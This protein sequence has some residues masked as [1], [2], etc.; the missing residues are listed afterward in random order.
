MLHTMYG[1]SLNRDFEFFI[2]Y[3]ALDLIVGDGVCRGLTAWKLD[4]GTLRK[5]SRSIR[6]L[7]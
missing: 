1:Q 4:D 5:A 7:D 2:E 6:R 3:F